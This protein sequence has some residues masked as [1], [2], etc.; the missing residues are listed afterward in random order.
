[1]DGVGR[2]SSS[3]N[4]TP[5]QEKKAASLSAL[6]TGGLEGA[7]SY[8]TK[9]CLIICVNLKSSICEALV[10]RE[11]RETRES[12]VVRRGGERFSRCY[13]GMNTK[14]CMGLNKPGLYLSSPPRNCT[15]RSELES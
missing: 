1:M 15:Q 10:E 7:V 14:Q 4:D 6:I 13:K 2:L 11:T 12:C 3:C 5:Q 9:R 8:N